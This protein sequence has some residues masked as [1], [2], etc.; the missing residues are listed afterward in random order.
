MY[1]K[2]LIY[3][4][5]KMPKQS[6][7]LANQFFCENKVPSLCISACKSNYGGCHAFAQ[8]LSNKLGHD[9]IGACMP[10]FS[11]Y[12]SSYDTTI[13]TFAERITPQ[14]AYQMFYITGCL[15]KKPHFFTDI[16]KNMKFDFSKLKNI[17]LIRVPWIL[18]DRTSLDEQYVNVPY[19]INVLTSDFIS[20]SDY[21]I[22][23]P[24]PL[25]PITA[26]PEEEKLMLSE[27]TFG[28]TYINGLVMQPTKEQLDQRE[29][30]LKR[31]FTKIANLA[32]DKEVSKPSVLILASGPKQKDV[33]LSEALAHGITI[34]FQD[35]LPSDKFCYALK[36]LSAKSGI[37][38]TN[39][40]MT[41][42]QATLL[43]CNVLFHGN[44]TKDFLT[45]LS[46]T[47]PKQHQSVA[48]EILGL[49]NTLESDKYPNQVK[50]IYSFFKKITENS[51]RKFEMLKKSSEEKKA[52]TSCILS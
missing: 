46:L 13:L 2:S 5:D 25:P 47:V 18:V 45:Q 50:E 34:I 35:R 51:I 31:Y 9:Y 43:G 33:Y 3:E 30:Y 17:F 41:F 22:G 36:E 12:T 44:K 40:V 4:D 19:N 20:D 14:T 16:N 23:L 21:S 48:K 39:G 32:R 11:N 15:L 8:V 10:G 6:L 28:I 1:N 37:L 38:G 49:S 7:I 52:P 29:I 27:S 26:F 42:I 24:S